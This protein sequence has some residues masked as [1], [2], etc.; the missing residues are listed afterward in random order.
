MKPKLVVLISGRG[1]NLKAIIDNINSGFLDVEISAIISNKKDAKGL[2]YA[3]LAACPA[4]VLDDMNFTSRDDYDSSLIKLIDEFQ[5]D[6]VILAGFMRILTKGFV[7]HYAGRLLNIHPSL[8]PKYKGLNTHKRVLQAGDKT[9]GATVHYVTYELDSGPVI[10]QAEV[11]VLANDDEDTLAARV[12]EQEHKLYSAAIK[13]A[14]EN[15]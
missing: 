6:L 9:H 12:L 14:I 2:A 15:K 10:M 3:S 13:K 4:K 8:L 1:S 11:P 7:E 5:P